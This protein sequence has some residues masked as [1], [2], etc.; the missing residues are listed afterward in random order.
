[1]FRGRA[2]SDLGSVLGLIALF[3]F[4]FHDAERLSDVAMICL[5][6][7]DIC[8]TF[9]CWNSECRILGLTS[10]CTCG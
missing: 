1:M 4:P 10:A 5:G 9:N 3:C 8:E 6:D 7:K 2:T